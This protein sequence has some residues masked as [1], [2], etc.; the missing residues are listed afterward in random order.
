MQQRAEECQ[1][2][3]PTKNWSGRLPAWSRKIFT[4]DSLRKEFGNRRRSLGENDGRYRTIFERSPLG[5]VSYDTRGVTLECNEKF[6]ELMGSTREKL[7]GFNLAR[8]GPPE[9]REVINRALAGEVAVYEGAYVSVTGGK[10]SFIRIIFN[11]VTPGKSP[12]Q[13]IATVEDVS[14][15]RLA[16]EVIER[17][18]LSLTQPM[19]DN[20]E[21]VFEDLFNLDDIQCLQDDFARATGVASIITHTDGTPLTL[22]SNFT[23]LCTLI[24]KTEK[25]CADCFN[26]GA[27]LGRLSTEGPFVR[28]CAGCG[29][30]TAG[31]GISV[32]G[33]HIVNAEDF[34]AAFRDVPIMSREHF[35][36][37]AGALFTLASRLSTTAYQN[38]QQARFITEI[39]ESQ[40]QLRESENRLRFALEG[41]NDGLWDANLLT[42]MMH[43]SGR[44]HEILGYPAEEVDLVVD[45]RT[46]VHAD[47]LRLS[48]DLL[49]AH[50]KK[51]TP[52]LRV[53]HRLRMKNGEWKWVLTRGKVVKWDENGWALRLTGTITDITDRVEAEAEKK[54]LQAQLMQAQKM[55][56]I[57]RLAGGVAHDFNNM[58]G[59]ILGHAELAQD[60]VAPA[61]P[62]FEDLSEIKKAAQRSA[63]LT[64]QL[65][66]FARKQ[67]VLPK[68]LDLNGTV[69]GLLKMLRRLIGE[70]IDLVWLPG[71]G[72]WQVKIDPTQVDQ[73][74]ANL[75]VNARDAI[76]GVGRISIET[77]NAVL[78]QDFC[79]DHVGLVP[80]NYVMLSISDDG[81]GMSK[82]VLEHIFEPFFTTKEVGQGTGLGLATTYGIVKQNNGYIDVYSEPGQGTTFRIYLP[83]YRW[84]SLA[85]D[86]EKV[87]DMLQQGRETILLVEDEP[88]ILYLS[89]RMLESMGYRVLA[90]ATPGEAMRLAE[91]NCGE[92]HLLM[93]DVIMPEM[94]GRDLARRLLSLYPDLR[95]LFMS[96][97]TADIIA[98]HGVLDEGVYFIQK[99]FSRAELS[100][101]VR[102]V[103]KGEGRDE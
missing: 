80:G 77:N 75:T 2:N 88:S 55:E 78:A 17:R 99:P 69:E 10:T 20:A 90:A 86:R 18:I 43:L 65:L 36:E 79:T 60:Q 11:P 28:P 33:H 94:N 81:C 9:M 84:Q 49:V 35:G 54:N 6:V 70:D 97:Y 7:L 3:R 15:R 42:G 93:T 39:K 5:V 52:I 24:R 4:T 102:A 58:L 85:N 8:Q 61:D 38:V 89:K 56:S 32:G 101:K 30:W 34:V 74:L 72:L 68:V 98:H 100:T 25:G 31:S 62:I 63:D 44:T 14:Q 48:W 41:A 46:L 53:E 16:Q 12:S 66:A 91:E 23:R 95:R 96:G 27:A 29:L 37:I 71:K 92:I 40:E 73:I 1:S 26:F 59:V 83:R 82:E 21:I 19:E 45:W 13:V 67:T 51:Q 47:D 22:P 50:L 103:L 87:K 76:E 64:R 57:G